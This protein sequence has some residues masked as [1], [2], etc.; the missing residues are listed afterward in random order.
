MLHLTTIVLMSLCCQWLIE[1]SGTHEIPS[2]WCRWKMVNT[3]M[4]WQSLCWLS[5]SCR[6]HITHGWVTHSHVFHIYWDSHYSLSKRGKRR[7]GRELKKKRGM[8][9]IVEMAGSSSWMGAMI[10]MSRN[11]AGEWKR[12]VM[13][14]H[15][16]STDRIHKSVPGLDGQVEGRYYIS[17]THNNL[18]IDK[19]KSLFKNCFGTAQHQFWS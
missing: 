7:R 3:E 5:L 2:R 12:C 17:I 9:W 18:S 16:F 4:H 14:D 6:S 1:E 19:P 15:I 13:F 11:T 8:Q 10:G